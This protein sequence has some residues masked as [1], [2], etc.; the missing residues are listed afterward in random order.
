MLNELVFREVFTRS[1]IIGSQKSMFSS[2][3]V[4]GIGSIE[5]VLN[6]VSFRMSLISSVVTNSN[7]VSFLN[8]V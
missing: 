8:P 5:D 1:Q 2:I 4:D 7:F 6:P 3:K